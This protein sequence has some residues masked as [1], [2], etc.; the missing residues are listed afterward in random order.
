M[1][2]ISPNYT[3]VNF[4]GTEQA[5]SKNV[6]PT[7]DSPQTKSKDMSNTIKAGI[8]LG[9]LAV[10]VIAG[11]A[12]KRGL[13]KSISIKT[14]QVFEDTFGK[15]EEVNGLLET[16]ELIDCAKYMAQNNKNITQTVLLKLDEKG[17]AFLEATM[18]KKVLKD[19]F[20]KK[21]GL[22]LLFFDKKSNFIESKPI[23]AD[24]IED[25]ISNMFGKESWIKLT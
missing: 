23:L 21:K 22:M 4:R 1:T 2:I 19:I 9:A 14:R 24:S 6:E 18:D 11:L 7:N 16:K 20:S 5:K 17:L 12:I 13:N 10:S 15:I 25:G 8:G 3:V